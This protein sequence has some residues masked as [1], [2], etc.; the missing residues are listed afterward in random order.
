M[1]KIAV[2]ASG[3]GT[4]AQNLADYFSDNHQ[5]EIA[6]IYSN[7]ASAFVHERAKRMG[8]PSTTFTREEFK[9]DAFVRQLKEEGINCIVLAGFLWL[10]PASLIKGFDQKIINIH[11]SLLPAFGGKGMY[12]G[13]VHEAVVASGAT[14]SG[15]TIHLVNEKYDE[16]KVLFQAKTAVTS[17][18][19]PDSLAGRI[20][21]LEY[22]HFPKVIEKYLLE[23]NL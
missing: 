17:I 14:E 16:G 7:R 18:D 5:I 6:K 3:S 15:I 12:G 4:N 2:F 13:H 23:G 22:E 8:I 20:H 21:E 11:P 9:S 1:H 10:I 19:D